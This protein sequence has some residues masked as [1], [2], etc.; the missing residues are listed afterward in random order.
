MMALNQN[1]YKL[2]AS[3]RSALCLGLVVFAHI[4]ILY[5][6][7]A[8]NK[9]LP[10]AKASVSPMMASL[11]M[12]NTETP[13]LVNKIN[14]KR[15]LEQAVEQK[16]KSLTKALKPVEVSRD[17]VPRLMPEA[18]LKPSAEISEVR[19]LEVNSEKATPENQTLEIKHE[20]EQ[21]IAQVKELAIELPRFGAAYLNN[22]SPEYPAASRRFSEQ[23][24]VLLRV[25]VSLSGQ[26]ESVQIQNSSGYSRLDQAAIKA[27]KMWSFIPAKRNN[28][29]LSAYVLVPV[30]FSLTG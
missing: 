6:L 23:G 2:E 3:S 1:S 25:L 15:V 9:T 14:Q 19:S 18:T 30:K 7:I 11:V 29:P 4:V 12:P 17:V 13:N 5:S 8:I 26:V 10:I 28:Q 24:I 22:P 21:A 20:A 27:V 16:P